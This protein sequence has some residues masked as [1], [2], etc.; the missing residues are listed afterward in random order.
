[1]RRGRADNRGP[2]ATQP[3][4]I[5][6]P[7][8]K[9]RECLLLGRPVRGGSTHE[10]SKIERLRAYGARRSMRGGPGRPRSSRAIATAFRARRAPGGGLGRLAKGPSRWRRSG[11]TA[12]PA[13]PREEKPARGSARDDPLVEALER[14]PS[15]LG[16]APRAS[17]VEHSGTLLCRTAERRRP[18]KRRRPQ[19]APGTRDIAVDAEGQR[20][21]H[22]LRRVPGE[23]VERVR[24]GKARA[25]SQV[26]HEPAPRSASGHSTASPIEKPLGRQVSSS[27]FFSC[28]ALDAFDSNRFGSATVT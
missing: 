18:H 8:S 24:I 28:C 19:T 20:L 12:S 3:P 26:R 22:A 23:R 21:G 25:G 16:R 1:M 7:R 9:R 5:P 27:F 17:H 10:H 14:S 4:S 11:T 6:G 15:P 13:I 2:P